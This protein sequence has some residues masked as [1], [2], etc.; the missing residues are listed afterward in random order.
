VPS[1]PPDAGGFG[2][3]SQL[4]E[5]ADQA[6]FESQFG[7]PLIDTGYGHPTE[8]QWGGF[9]ASVIPVPPSAAPSF[10]SIPEAPNEWVPI[11][12]RL[13]PD[14]GG[15]LLEL[16]GNW[17]QGAYRIR[18][19]SNPGGV[20]FPSDAEGTYAYAAVPGNQFDIIPNP[21][22]EFLRVTVPPMP[23]GLYDLILYWG[24]QWSTSYIADSVLEVATRTRQQAVYRLRSALPPLWRTGPRSSADEDLL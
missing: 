21:P 15:F 6:D 13:V 23:T 8:G 16:W 5:G 24:K 9:W 2:Y 7:G 20:F 22:R 3:G 10:G 18:F 1:A 19:K 12:M 11:A 4:P 17:K 14:D